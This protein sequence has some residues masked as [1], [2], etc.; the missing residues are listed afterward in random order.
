MAAVEILVNFSAFLRDK[1]TDAVSNPQCPVDLK[2]SLETL[3]KSQTI[4]YSLVTQLHTFLS[5]EG[6]VYLHE[7]LEGS[8]VVLPEVEKPARNPQLESRCQKLRAELANKDYRRM[9]GDIDA[10]EIMDRTT[11]KDFG[12]EMKAVNRQLVSV[13]NFLITVA[14][15]FAF[16]YKATE[17]SLDEPN[18]PA[19]LCSGLVLSTLVFFADLYFLLMYNIE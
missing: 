1:I 19:Q 9:V 11:T 3:G 8:E 15:A 18:V 6:D 2:L 5:K 16:G 13:F 14:G 4:P 10:V 17:Y 12:K 7:L